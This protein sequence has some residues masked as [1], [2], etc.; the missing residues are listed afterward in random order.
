MADRCRSLASL[1]RQRHQRVRDLRHAGRGGPRLCPAG[2]APRLGEPEGEGR[3][4][5]RLDAASQ[6]A[7]GALAYALLL[8][9][10]LAASRA[11]ARNA[12]DLVPRRLVKLPDLLDRVVE[13]LA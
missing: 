2:R 1:L 6:G 13:S 4:G 8:K 11:E 10:E 3:P 12:L 5:V 7:R 9:G